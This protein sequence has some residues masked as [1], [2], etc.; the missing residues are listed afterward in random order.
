MTMHVTW[1]TILPHPIC[2]SQVTSKETNLLQKYADFLAP[3][4][5]AKTMAYGFP[6]SKGVGEI[7]QD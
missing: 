3:S 5:P 4:T 6:H 7:G 2:L 1:Q